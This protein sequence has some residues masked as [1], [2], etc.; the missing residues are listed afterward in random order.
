MLLYGVHVH[1]GVEDRS[2]VLPICNAI[3][4]RA[5]QLQSLAASSPFWAGEDTRYASNRAMVFQQLPTAGMPPQFEKW[6]ELERYH[7]GMLKTGV[8]ESF[9]ELR[10]DVRPSIRLGTVE[11][12]IF[13][14]C[15]NILEVEAVASLAHCLVEYYSSKLDAGDKLPM[16]PQ[17]FVDENKWRSARYGMDA[18]LILDERGTEEHVRDTTEKLLEELEP[19]AKKLGCSG[20]LAKVRQILTYGASYQ[21]QRAVA[22]AEPRHALDNVVELMRAEMGA[23]SPLSP[24]MFLETRENGSKHSG[25]GRRI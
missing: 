1:V 2:K 14:A 12:R 18:I 15:T 24:Q 3:I 19:T 17:W 11:I 4:T 5:G 8:I 10:W 22:A 16:L 25:A 6:E 9:D 23:D 7:D 20:G 21:R 13:D